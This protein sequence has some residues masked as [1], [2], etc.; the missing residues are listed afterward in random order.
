MS[1]TVLE[2]LEI[3]SWGVRVFWELANV[4][5]QAMRRAGVTQGC[6]ENS[7]DRLQIWARAISPLSYRAILSLTIANTR[8]VE[9]MD[10][11]CK[12]CSN[13]VS[14][15]RDLILGNGEGYVSLVVLRWLRVGVGGAVKG[16]G[17]AACSIPPITFH[18]RCDASRASYFHC[19]FAL[20]SSLCA[21][22]LEQ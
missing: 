20:G 22:N 12:S 18:H 9:Y 6:P 14:L 17:G 3:I 15:G 1:D 2:A 13:E 5:L 16:L 11:F 7:S 19:R 10:V 21:N 8:V 4:F